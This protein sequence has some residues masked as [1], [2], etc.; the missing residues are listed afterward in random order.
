MTDVL[1][2]EQ[3]KLNMSRIRG[4]D[5]RPEMVVRSMV[6]GLGYR[7]SLYNSKLPGKPDLVLTR[8]RKIIFVHGCFWH[9]H[10][11]DYGKVIP[12]TRTDFWQ[13]KRKGNVARDRRNLAALKRAGWK[14]LVVWECQT[15]DLP[16]LEK[17]LTK[18]LIGV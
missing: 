13:N 10:S 7:Y 8:H 2:P 5:T 15:K 4:R 11:C 17:R 9:M 16:A 18:F 1:T 12:K 3:R 14:V 6:H